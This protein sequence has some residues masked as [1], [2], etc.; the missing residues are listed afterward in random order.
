VASHANLTTVVD[1]LPTVIGATCAIALGAGVLFV[2]FVVAWLNC[3]GR[4]ALVRWTALGA[5]AAFLL[6][7]VFHLLAA[8]H[9][10][11]RGPALSVGAALAAVAF[12]TSR[13]RAAFWWQ[14][15]RTFIRRVARRF[16]KSPYRVTVLIWLAG[17]APPI[18]RALILPPLGW[19][20]LTLHATKA[21][22]WVQSGSVAGMDGPG[23]WAYYRLQLAGAEVFLAWAM[24]P[25]RSDV[26]VP[27]VDILEWFALGLTLIVLARTLRI[28]EPFATTA[29]GF[30]LALPTVRLMIGA[31]YVEL[32]SM[33]ALTGGIALGA[34]SGKIRGQPLLLAGAL[35]GVA[36]ATKVNMIPIAGVA[37]LI[38]AIQ[39]L[40]SE[41]T[42][43]LPWVASAALMFAVAL[44]PWLLR[45][46]HETGSILAPLPIHVGGWAIGK[47]APEVDWLLHRSPQELAARGSELTVL[48]RVFARGGPLTPDLGLMA[49]VPIVMSLLGVSWLARRA[50]GPAVTVLV[51]SAC[52]VIMYFSDSFQ[53]L[54]HHWTSSSGRFL[55]PFVAFATLASVGWCRRSSRTAMVYGSAL[56]LLAVWNLFRFTGYGVSTASI[57]AM[58]P[59]FAT[60]AVLAICSAAAFRFVPL[61]WPL[62]MA[63]FVT[64]I[65]VL[66]EVRSVHRYDLFARDY[67]LRPF[68]A[69]AEALGPFASDWTP[70]ISL[71]DDPGSPRRIAVTSGP[72][73]DLDNWFAYPFLGRRLQNEVVYVPISGDNRLRHFG[74]DGLNEQLATSA[75]FDA[76][77]IRLGEQGITHVMSFA[78]ASI[79]LGWMEHSPDTFLRLVGDDGVWGLFAV[80]DDRGVSRTARTD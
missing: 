6:T 71:V 64:A 36:A 59:M 79:E 45:S 30:V 16:W 11:A 42:K 4:G 77:R 35:L 23:P 8:V 17:A 5:T 32:I 22:M 39:T 74:S 1:L 73:Q 61:R 26:L 67:V 49:V 62:L 27:L 10:F 9:L 66:N 24:L 34:A 33:A 44:G 80:K 19:D 56:W 54:R 37:L 75:S 29:A 63:I 48:K 76:W 31:G 72:H 38:L 65:V 78:P 13:G 14:R 21:A 41:R 47:S 7:A 50:P 57:D 12:L 70:A 3:G 46:F 43:A 60:A 2:A 25:M 68:F 51:V 58:L 40:Y 18:L 15:E 55:V 52:S 69:R 28:R 53:V 20:A